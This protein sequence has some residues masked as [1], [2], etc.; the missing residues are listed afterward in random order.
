MSHDR[1]VLLDCTFECD[2]GKLDPKSYELRRI[3]PCER[4]MLCLN[5]AKP[6]GMIMIENGFGIE[7]GD[8]RWKNKRT[9]RQ[10]ATWL[11]GKRM[12]GDM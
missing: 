12:T 7:K 5:R 6:G 10:R 8:A 3:G 11:I 1:D 4:G 2:E 9:I